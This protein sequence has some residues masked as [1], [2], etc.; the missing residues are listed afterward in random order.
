MIRLLPALIALAALKG[1]GEVV[2]FGHVVRENP[3]K[4]E[5]AAPDAATAADA[6]SPSS[7]AAAPKPTSEAAASVP[8]T[9]AAAPKPATVDEPARR[10]GATTTAGLPQAHAVHAVNVTLSPT[11]QP[12]DASVDAA[13]LLDAI[14][15][16]LRSRN[17]LDEQNP[18]AD[19]TAEVRIESAT[20]HPTV[21][22]V[23]FG[24]QPMAGTLT[25]ELHVSRVSGEQLPASRIVAESRWSVADDGHDK[26][27]QG[28]LYR[29]FAEL[30]ADELI[31]TA[32]NPGAAPEKDLQK[33]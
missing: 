1:C 7:E 20:A 25:G 3:A 30:T 33:P 13:A 14:R 21:N 23:I 26:N 28:P 24:R 31:A 4:T 11:S 29:R 8:A 16:E 18:S 10:T 2:V 6:S 5:A 12:G 32:S 9:E 27:P 17:L 19:G 15:T 22:A